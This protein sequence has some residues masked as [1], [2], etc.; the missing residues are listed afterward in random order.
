MATKT[1]EELKQLA[2]QIRDEKTNKQNT[3]TRVGTAMLEHINKLEQDYYDK[4]Q[5]DEELKE[6]DDKLTELGFKIGSKIELTSLYYVRQKEAGEI[7]DY[8]ISNKGVLTQAKG[9]LSK[10][11]YVKKGDYIKIEGAKN[12]NYSAWAFYSE[13]PNTESSPAYFSAYTSEADFY[14]ESPIDGYVLASNAPIYGDVIMYLGNLSLSDKINRIISV[15]D[16]Y[17][18]VEEQAAGTIQDYYITNKGK[19]ASQS[20]QTTKYCKVN[21]GDLIKIDTINNDNYSVWALFTGIPDNSSTPYIFMPYE[22][23]KEVF[24]VE[25]PID[26]YIATSGMTSNPIRA[27][28]AELSNYNEIVNE[29]V[30][31]IRNEVELLSYSYDTQYEDIKVIEG[32]YFNIQGKFKVQSGQQCKYCFVKENDMIRILGGTNKNAYAA[33]AFFDEEP[34][35]DSTASMYIPYTSELDTYVIAPRDGYILGSSDTSRDVLIFKASANRTF[36][37]SY[38]GLSILYIGDSISSSNDCYWKGLIENNYNIKYVRNSS[39]GLW[40]AYPGIHVLPKEFDSEENNSS[41]IWYRCAQ[42][43]MSIYSFDMISLFG[44]TNDM[45]VESLKIGTVDDVAYVDNTEGITEIDENCTSEKPAELSF[46][47]ALKGCIL[48]LKRDFP[49][50]EIVIPTVMPCGNNYGNWTDSETGLKASEAMAIL[51]MKIAEKYKLKAIPLYWDMRTTE[52]VAAFAKD[53]VHPNYQGALRI[54]ALFA[55]TLCL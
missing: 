18:Y 4:T 39:D 7:A 10:Y 55:Q 38:N 46:A 30:K 23:N 43:R 8:Y 52:N 1:F 13:I 54:Q 33:W 36:K 44:G 48:M 24:Y 19:L 16:P 41:S 37:N 49:N 35:I 5:T 25:S 3:A 45:T 22:D 11:F 53:Y 6:R 34:T 15:K 47:S 42:K 29:L 2:I 40:P 28:K 17:K 26:G 27:F 31:P 9:Q 21:K 14:V 50:K 51:Q 12:T 20:N 32:C